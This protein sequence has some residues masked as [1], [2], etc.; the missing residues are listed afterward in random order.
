MAWKVFEACAPFLEATVRAR[1]RKPSGTDECEG[2]SGTRSHPSEHTRM[3]SR[4]NH[5]IKAL[6]LWSL[7]CIC[8]PRV[9]KPIFVIQLKA[10]VPFP[11]L[12]AYSLGQMNFY[13]HPGFVLACLF[14]YIAKAHTRAS[15]G[16]FRSFCGFLTHHS[17]SAGR[18][19]LTRATAQQPGG[20]NRLVRESWGRARRRHGERRE[21][22]SD[23][24]KL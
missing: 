4:D 16:D 22:S 2:P 19:S 24:R 14:E 13:I 15:I 20:R 5:L 12:T 10:H 11:E 9:T 23:G 7:S 17:S 8:S 18:L 3:G 1:A 6:P 21:D